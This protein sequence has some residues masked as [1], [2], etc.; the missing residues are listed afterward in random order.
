ML[1]RSQ[2][3]ASKTIATKRANGGSEGEEGE[4]EKNPEA[5]KHFEDKYGVGYGFV[6]AVVMNTCYP[7]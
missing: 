7:W 3:E 4:G 1:I 2:T 5:I 6:D